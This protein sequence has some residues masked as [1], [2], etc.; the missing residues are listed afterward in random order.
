MALPIS[1]Q[2]AGANRAAFILSLAEGSRSFDAGTLLSGQ[3]LKAGAVLG[4]IAVG[5]ATSAAKTAGGANTGNG[6]M[7]SVTV[8]AG[9]KA[10]VY[11]L[12]IV[13]PGTNVGSFQVED[14]DGI[15]IGVGVVAA[16]FSAGGLAFT[17]A[18]GSTDF[19]VGDGFD[20]TVAAGSGKFREIDF[21]SA[22]GA[23]AA[24]GILYDNVDASGGDQAATIMTRAAEV[25]SAELVWPSGATTNQKN[26]AIAQLALLGIVVRS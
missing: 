4:K 15:I 3:N 11:R 14:P 24:V 2:S 22:V 10:G 8:S 26:A 13:E 17:L 16:A 23:D 12:R 20:I 9:A 7:G 6:T 5:T 25:K 1:S 19:V 21:A 18:D